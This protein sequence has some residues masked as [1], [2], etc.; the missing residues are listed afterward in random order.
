MEIIHLTTE[1][2]KDGVSE[3]VCLVD[4]WASWCG[5]C[6]MLAPILEELAVKYQGAVTICKVDVDAEPELAQS[7]GVMSIPTVIV[8][9]DGVPNIKAT[10]VQPIEAYDE[11][12]EM[13]FT[14][15]Q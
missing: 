11:M 7:F 3:G 10:G 9:K 8:F 4:F 1:T 13:Q 14:I 6:L 15:R 2:F 12:I 5:P